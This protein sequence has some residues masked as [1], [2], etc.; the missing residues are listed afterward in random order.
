M[1]DR[2]VIVQQ[3]RGR[4]KMKML[5]EVGAT[6]SCS[7]PTPAPSHPRTRTVAHAH[8]QEEREQENQAML[9]LMRRYQEEDE[10]AAGKT[11]GKGQG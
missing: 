3:I 1:E 10:A 9:A 2:A 4:E 6:H 8:V 11:W 5:Q 7:R